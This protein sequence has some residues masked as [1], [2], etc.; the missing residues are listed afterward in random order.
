MGKRIVSIPSVMI[1]RVCK[2]S[3]LAAGV[4]LAI[5]AV[6]NQTGRTAVTGKRIAAITSIRLGSVYGVIKKMEHAKIIAVIR[7]R[8]KTNNYIFE[9][10]E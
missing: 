2:A 10:V 6:I 3:P 4:Y 1:Y 7:K 8:G 9:S 5:R